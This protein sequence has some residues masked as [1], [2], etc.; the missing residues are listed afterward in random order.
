VTPGRRGWIAFCAAA[1]LA[2]LLTAAP[3]SASTILG[4]PATASDECD[5]G[6]TY[7][8]TVSTGASYTAPTAGV[9][10]SWSFRADAMPPQLK[11]KLGRSEGGTAYTIVGAS[12]VRA[13]VA[14]VL[15][16]FPAQIP[17]QAGDV[18]GVTPV[19]AG[20]CGKAPASG[21]SFHYFNGDPAPGTTATYLGPYSGQLTVSALLEPDCDSDGF[22][23]ESQDSSVDC[24]PP[25]TQISKGPKQKTHTKKASFE[26]SSSEPNSSFECSLNGGAFEP[27]ASPAEVKAKKGRNSFAVRAKDSA[28][29]LDASPASFGWKVRKKRKH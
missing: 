26:F 4:D 9:I 21:Y 14:N 2:G 23:D 8:Q 27:C 20:H 19:T 28:G 15:N 22:G 29:N 17:V 12:S 6:L 3:A 16:T 10:T 1:A 7:L 18:L 5:P 13:P 11:I 24:A 25:E